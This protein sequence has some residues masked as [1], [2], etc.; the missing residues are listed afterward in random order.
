VR[1]RIS[2]VDA[3]AVLVRMIAVEARQKKQEMVTERMRAR[4][5]DG[6]SRESVGLGLVV[7]EA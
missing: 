7:D 4:I 6:A 5:T 1:W 3:P 2:D